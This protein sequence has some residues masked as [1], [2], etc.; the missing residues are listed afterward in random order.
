MF[1]KLN[2]DA[3]TIYFI[4]FAIIIHVGA[5]LL[6]LKLTEFNPIS[7]YLSAGILIINIILTVLFTR[8]GQLLG[9]ILAMA[10]FFTQLIVLIPI[11]KASLK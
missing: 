1:R 3:K 6:R 4:I 11:L 5:W 7:L 10:T 2:L 9:Y 8:K